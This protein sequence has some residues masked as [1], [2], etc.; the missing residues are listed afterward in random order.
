LGGYLSIQYALRHPDKVRA[1]ALIAPLYSLNQISPILR[2][3]NHRPSLAAKAIQLIPLAVIDTL[4]GWDP[5]NAVQFSAEARWQIAVD[6]KR[7]SPHILNMLPTI[8]DLTPE[9]GKLEVPSQIIWGENDLTLNPRSF[10]QLLSALPQG[11]GVSIR[12][13]G[14]QPH[15]GEPQ[16]VNHLI[17]DFICQH[18]G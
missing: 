15:I 14:H 18:P 10:P 8:P 13:C 11:T 9:L 2:W 6:Y 5:I 16:R 4:L 3:L 7:A 12:G 17:L 1:L